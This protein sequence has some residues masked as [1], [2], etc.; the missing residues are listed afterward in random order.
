MKSV[1]EA[2]G[3]GKLPGGAGVFL[4]V[5]LLKL[6]FVPAPIREALGAPRQKR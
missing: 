2:P 3:Y 1:P 4:S 6:P 5:D